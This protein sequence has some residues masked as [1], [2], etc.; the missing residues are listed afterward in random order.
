MEERGKSA[1]K[2][3]KELSTLEFQ[4]DELRN[5][6]WNYLHFGK[7]DWNNFKKDF[8]EDLR[9]LNDDLARLENE[10]Q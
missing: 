6:L 3:W 2:H 10:I 7:G 9:P 4:N 1:V 8:V 5:G